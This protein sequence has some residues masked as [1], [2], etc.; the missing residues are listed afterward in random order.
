MAEQACNIPSSQLEGIHPKLADRMRAKYNFDKPITMGIALDAAKRV[1][2]ARE[3]Q[4]LLADAFTAPDANGIPMQ[5][6]EPPTIQEV[7][8]KTRDRLNLLAQLEA[9]QRVVPVEGLMGMSEDEAARGLFEAGQ[10]A[11]LSELDRVE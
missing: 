8:N 7:L 3:Y 11:V 5:K 1:L 10:R 9:K 4:E 2:P 6:K